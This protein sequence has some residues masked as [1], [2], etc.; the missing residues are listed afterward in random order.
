LG[1][2][3]EQVK[4]TEKKKGIA[5][6]IVPT[7]KG[8]TAE[9]DPGAKNTT[10]PVCKETGGGCIVRDK[11]RGHRERR[12]GKKSQV[13]RWKRPSLRVP[14]GQSGDSWGPRVGAEF[15][16]GGGRDGRTY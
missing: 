9:R 4:A 5:K 3:R 8:K 11:T 2:R 16:R 7:P 12:G 10:R 13:S 1:E 15:L 14:G 6:D